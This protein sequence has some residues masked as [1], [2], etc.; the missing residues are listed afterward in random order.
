VR[1]DGH[2]PSA[3]GIFLL[4]QVV[5]FSLY[6]HTFSRM[7]RVATAMA[8]ALTFAIYL[9]TS[10]IY[11]GPGHGLEGGLSTRSFFRAIDSITIIQRYVVDGVT[12]TDLF[13]SQARP[14]EPMQNVGRY[15]AYPMPTLEL[16]ASEMELAPRPVL[17]SYQAYAPELLRLDAEFLRGS[18]SPDTLFIVLRPIDNRYPA[19]DDSLSWP[20]L[21][22]RYELDMNSNERAAMLRRRI[23][24]LP[25]TFE[26]LNE[27]HATAGQ[28]ID[29]PSTTEGPIWVEID[30][31]ITAI[32]SGLSTLYKPPAM[33]M[34][35]GLVDGSVET[36]RLIP[37]IGKA[38]FFLSPAVT[39]VPHF[40]AMYQPNARELLR[41]RE[42]RRINMSIE[43]A[44]SERYITS[45]DVR[46]S[47]LKF[48]D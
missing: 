13:I 33:S 45:V 9:A 40:E 39:T 1:Q 42:I 32:Y 16:A 46:F 47:R 20:E 15:D 43:N 24:P 19:Q 18:N 6:W 17:H 31:H 34:R 10:A 4:I 11:A 28:W 35:V 3:L 2:V 38:G 29:V 26:Q 14:I 48:G 12:P 37:L 36:Y 23:S 30:A 25:Y 7:S 21:L 22:S 41:E 44:A 5:L 8:G 27:V